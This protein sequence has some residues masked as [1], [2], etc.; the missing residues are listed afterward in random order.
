VADW[1]V[2]GGVPF[3]DAHEITGQLVALCAAR[4]CAL[5]DV[6]DAD[7]AAVSEHL[8]PQVREVLS[9]RGAL[10]ARTTPGSTGPAAVA[11]QLA[12]VQDL[13]DGWR[14]WAAERVVPR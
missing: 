1:L 8:T 13:L 10:N 2:R 4:E 9:V 3:R 12:M 6:S 11:D 14:G 5:S 7:L